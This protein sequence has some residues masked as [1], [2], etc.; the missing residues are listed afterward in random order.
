MPKGNNLADWFKIAK[1]LQNVADSALLGRQTTKREQKLQIETSHV[2]NFDI[3]V[4]DKELCFASRQLFIDGH[5][6]RSVEEA[7]K[8]LDNTVKSMS[9]LDNKSGADLMHNAFSPNRPILRLNE[10]QTQSDIDEQKGYMHLFAGSMSGIRNPRAHE[11]TLVDTPEEAL[12]MLVLANHLMRK[13]RS[14]TK[15]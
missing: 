10:L 7:F 6:A 1:N 12:E 11:H 5:Y 13:L 3:L 9:E 2:D 8:C 4:T 14:A 15:L